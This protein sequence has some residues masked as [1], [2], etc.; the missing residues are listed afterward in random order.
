[1]VCTLSQNNQH[2]DKQHLHLVVN[3]E[4]QNGIEILEGQVLCNLRIKT[5]KIL[6]GSI[7]QEPLG[8]P[9]C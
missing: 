2:V 9:K 8:L 4:L 5:V 1:M 3:W 6:V 7:T